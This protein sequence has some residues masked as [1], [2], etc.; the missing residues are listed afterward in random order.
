[1]GGISLK[2]SGANRELTRE[3]V[4]V[5]PLHELPEQWERDNAL[6]RYRIIRRSGWAG[7][8]AVVLLLVGTTL[9]LLGNTYPQLV[10]VGLLMYGFALLSLLLMGVRVWLRRRP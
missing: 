2:K 10:I 7:R 6:F 8:A 1:M 3:E 9:F 4:Y 5:P